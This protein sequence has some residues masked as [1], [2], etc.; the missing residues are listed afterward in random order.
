MYFESIEHTSIPV[1]NAT[2]AVHLIHTGKCQTFECPVWKNKSGQ[3]VALVNDTDIN[4][5]SF[6]EVAVINIDTMQQYESISFAWCKSEQKKLDFILGCE[7]NQPQLQRTT[8]LPIDGQGNETT[9]SF[10][11]GCCGE[12]F[13]ST[14]KK[15]KKF[16]QDSGYGIC[17]NC[18][19]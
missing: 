13:N 5:P 17:N 19:Q 10:T 4:S 9:A 2:E 7:N 12:T 14:I 11:C 3:K 1:A 18:V 16:D 8:N 6:A 15:Q